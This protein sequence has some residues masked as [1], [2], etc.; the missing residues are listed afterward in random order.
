MHLTLKALFSAFLAEIIQLSR[1]RFLI[2]LV[3]FQAVTFLI[4]VTLFGMTGAF[5]P[6]AIIDYDKSVYSKEF[7]KSLEGAH[8]SFSLKY[9]NDY[10]SAKEKIKTGD[11]VAIIMIPF[12][13]SEGIN[14]GTTVTINVVIDNIDTDM[15]MDI[16]RALPAAIIN[17]GEKYKFPGIRVQTNETDLI[18]HDTDFIIYMVV[19]SLILISLIISGILSGVAVAQEFESK[20]IE[21]LAVSPI[22]PIFIFLGRILATNIFS[23]AGLLLTSIIAMIG[24]GIRPIYPLNMIA[25]LLVSIF[26]FGVIGAAIGVIMKKTLPVVSII[27][28]ISLPIYLFSGTY[29]PER[30]DG[31]LL[32]IMAHFTPVYYAVGII[33]KAVLNLKVTPESVL[34]NY[35]FLGGWII[36]A[37]GIT[38]YFAKKNL[39]S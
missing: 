33:E 6:T 12:G 13:F 36:F 25:V 30:F 38:W 29:E 17:F 21:V 34:L 5:A 28:G 2:V 39:I 35:L 8:H 22:H 15:S 1:S 19:S 23:A 18:D 3:M 20:T 14:L 37:L 24:W 7:I 31:N 16:E 4:L 11:L 10:K 26:L 32:W 27:F 9:Y